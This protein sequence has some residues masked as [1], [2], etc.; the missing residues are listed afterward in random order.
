MLRV[1]M[2]T[3]CDLQYLTVNTMAKRR[4]ISLPF[5]P[6]PACPAPGL[7][8]SIAVATTN[9]EATITFDLGCSSA[10]NFDFEYGVAGFTQGSGMLLSNQSVAI[11]GTE[12]SY[13][14]TGLMANENYQVY[15]RANCGAEQ[16]AWSIANAFQTGLQ[17]Y[18]FR[19]ILVI[20]LLVEATLFLLLPLWKQLH[21]TTPI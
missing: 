1:L 12:A 2:L 17:P 20:K 6:P 13:T 10:T 18:F 3:P 11:N 5:L 14:L 4:I 15:Y 7:A 9:D 19:Q 8:T 16:S 21:L